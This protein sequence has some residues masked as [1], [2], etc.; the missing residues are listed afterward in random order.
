MATTLDN[1]NRADGALGTATSGQTWS[2]LT[3]TTAIATNKATV[4]AGAP[5]A[6]AALPYG[7][8]D[9]GAFSLKIAVSSTSANP[10]GLV[11]RILDNNNRIGVFLAPTTQKGQIFKT[12]GGTT[13]MLAEA[14]ATIAANTTYTVKA[15]LTGPKIDMYIDGVFCVTFTLT[16]GDETQ[17]TNAN[18][19]TKVGF[20]GDTTASFDD[21]VD[22]GGTSTITG[23]GIA[24]TEAFGTHVV[25]QVITL[26]AIGSTEAF[27]TAAVSQYLLPTGVGSLEALGS[28]TVTLNIAAEAIDTAE[29]FGDHEV[30][31]G[32]F[33]FFPDGI[34]STETF[35]LPELTTGVHKT[36]I[37]GTQ[38]AAVVLG[39]QPVHLYIGGEIVFS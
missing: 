38:V 21:L 36:F 22:E 8:H 11:M 30:E 9:N 27:G 13:T 37:G 7:N 10:A 17:Y 2:T 24:S 25:T 20:R 32:G 26:T 15:I 6:T 1:F 34:A 16:G 18:G 28:P 19:Y 35:G 5:S 33:S 39:T 23:T 31:I 12:D 4:T 3:G 29:A 14:N